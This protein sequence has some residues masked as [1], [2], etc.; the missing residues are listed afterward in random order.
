MASSKPAI[1]YLNGVFFPVFVGVAFC[2]KDYLREMKR[3]GVVNPP[4][5]H[6]SPASMKSLTNKQGKL[7]VIVCFDPIKHC[8]LHQNQNVS[9][10]AHEAVHVSD[11]IFKQIGEHTPG[12][13]TRAYLVQYVL[14]EILYI[15]D[16]YLKKWK[17]HA[18]KR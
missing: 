6:C 15:M 1:T 18:K 17:R 16:D 13:E 12:E 4:D 5:F 8:R 3:I 9:L 14:Q 7:T 10:I 2:E 11:A